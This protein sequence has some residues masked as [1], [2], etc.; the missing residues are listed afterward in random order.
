MEK[1]LKMQVIDHIN[2]TNNGY[3][4]LFSFDKHLRPT[5]QQMIEDRDLCLTTFDTSPA[6][7]FSMQLKASMRG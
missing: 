7:M 1:D 4:A 6:V 2:T 5:V 3:A